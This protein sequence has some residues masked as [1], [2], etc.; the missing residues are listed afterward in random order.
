[1]QK[2]NLSIY[3]KE[4]TLTDSFKLISKHKFMLMIT[5]LLSGIIGYLYD[6][7]NTYVSDYNTAREIET[8]SLLQLPPDYIF[9]TLINEN[10]IFFKSMYNKGVKTIIDSETAA[11]HNIFNLKFLS[12]NNFL[13]FLESNNYK[14]FKDIIVNELKNQNKIFKKRIGFILSRDKGYKT[15]DGTQIVFI[16]HNI[17]FDGAKILTEYIKHTYGQTSDQYLQQK[18]RQF[19]FVKGK[20]KDAYITAEQLDII[21]PFIKSKFTTDRKTY[22]L[23]TS[24]E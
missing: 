16:K 12:L 13:N 9:D 11:F 4:V 7:K 21:D 19:L 18:Q 1:M 17:N 14:N 24:T 23:T 8:H 15:I 10:E 2:K 3:E 20:Y 22:T 5:I 6:G